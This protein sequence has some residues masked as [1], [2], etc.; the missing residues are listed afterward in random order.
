MPLPFRLS[1]RSLLK[2]AA[3]LGVGAGL[4]ALGIGG[5]RGRAQEESEGPF[6]RESAT[7]LTLGNRFYEVDFDSR[8][9]AITRIFDKRG[10][11]VV[12]E[13]NADG[14]LW[15]LATGAW[16]VSWHDGWPWQYFQADRGAIT[17]FSW[18]W[19]E[20]K[21]TLA[22]EYDVPF[23]DGHILVQ[24]D[25]AIGDTP[26][27]DLTARVNNESNEQIDWL[28]FPDRLA[29]RS[30]EVERAMFPSMGGVFLNKSF[31]RKGVSSVAYQYPS[32]FAMGDLIWMATHGGSI[33]IYAIHGK[34][35]YWKSVVGFG[36]G[37]FGQTKLSYWRHAFALALAPNAT[38]DLPTM[39]LRLGNTP[40]Q[41]VIDYREDNDIH[42]YPDFREKV[43][44]YHEAARRSPTFTTSPW[45]G[46][47]PSTYSFVDSPALLHP[48]NF[49]EGGNYAL[50]NPD[51]WPPDDAYGGPS[52]Y[53]N[54]FS[55]AQ[56]D[57]KLVIPFTSLTAVHAESATV[58]TLEQEGLTISDI[59]ARDPEGDLLH[60]TFG[61][62]IESGEDI[63]PVPIIRPS[64][65]S[66]RY[67]A[68]LDKIMADL[69]AADSDFVFEDGFTNWYY[70]AHPDALSPLRYGH[71]WLEHAEQ[72]TDRNLTGEG[73]H[74]RMSKHMVGGYG[75]IVFVE[76]LNGLPWDEDDWT[77]FPATAVMLRD[78]ALY[79]S[80]NFEGMNGARWRDGD[81]TWT[82]LD[83]FRRHLALGW[84]MTFGMPHSYEADPWLPVVTAFSHH[85]VGPF[86][87]EVLLGFR[88]DTKSVSVS[89]FETSSVTANWTNLPHTVEQHRLSPGGVVLTGGDGSVTGGVF[90]GFNGQDLTS[91]EHY[92]IEQRKSSGIIIRQPMGDSTA[93]RIRAY[94]EWDNRS[95]VLISAF[96]RS[97]QL[98][99]AKPMQLRDRNVNFEYELVALESGNWDSFRA[100]ISLGTDKR[101]GLRLLDLPWT[102]TRVEFQ[103]GRPCLREVGMSDRNGWGWGMIGLVVDRDILGESG[104]AGVSIDVEWYDN[105]S[106]AEGQSQH[107]HGLS[108][109]YDGS[110]RNAQYDHSDPVAGWQPA[111][112]DQKWKATQFQCPRA[113]FRRGLT[114]QGADILISPPSGVCIGKVTVT[115][116]DELER[117]TVAYYTIHDP[118]Q[119]ETL[120]Q[121]LH[122]RGWTDATQPIAD[123]DLDGVGAI[124]D[125]DAEGER[126]RMYSPHVP[127]SANTLDRLEQGRAYYV[128]VANGRTLHWPEAPYGGVGFLL[129]P[130]RNL[131]CWLGTPDKPLTDAIAPL[132]GMKAEPLVS[133]T[134]DGRT[135]DVEESRSATEPLAY[136]QALWVEIDAVGPTRW[137]QF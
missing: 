91:D 18:V 24:V 98:V 122:L 69:E 41:A 114:E 110:V 5:E 104:E 74:D 16:P 82:M 2:A 125:W 132:R 46:E 7:T 86:A 65:S 102:E 21:Q 124:F 26:Y 123:L 37:T 108:L 134:L 111:V 59:A 51:W 105:A 57:G 87:D 30:D 109:V 56:R 131:V 55:K 130:G 90:Q 10:G 3:R 22:F 64:P 84:A 121:G 66:N 112:K 19:D 34:S 119:G 61:Y 126:W 99:T 103:D 101:D 72:Y 70:D 50:A 76:D 29:F 11:G 60:F 20:S 47:W 33:A 15:G 116:T 35:E 31:F 129:Q 43:G 73:I 25:I 136:G 115:N 94:S 113:I 80:H 4:A 81:N 127:A 75:T 95:R 52:A 13:G 137:L 85:V 1:R 128:R 40:V 53:L 45:T 79:W 83:L 27:L 28:T 32:W 88:G 9:G 38:A 133:L 49:Q 14:S 8:N 118:T 117:R 135:Y 96:N 54:V 100:S 36:H 42:Q 44:D 23:F 62:P 93:L 71:A 12:S 78:K 89:V 17:R 48:V 6:F 92:L 67:R 107:D 97:H 68:R 58:N 120:T 77:Y 63:D 106:L 39:R